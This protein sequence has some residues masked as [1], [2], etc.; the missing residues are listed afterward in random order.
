MSDYCVYYH[1][2]SEPKN[3]LFLVGILKSYEYVCFDRMLETQDGTVFEF[4]VPEEQEQ[5]FLDL[6]ARFEKMGVVNMVRKLPNRLIGMGL[7]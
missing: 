7:V 3:H 1:A 4:F 6:M 5:L 2:T